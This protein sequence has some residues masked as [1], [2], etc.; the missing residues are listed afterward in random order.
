MY[1]TINN[2]RDVKQ[3]DDQGNP[4]FNVVIGNQPIGVTGMEKG[5]VTYSHVD[6]NIASKATLTILNFIVPAGKVVELENVQASG[7]GFALYEVQIN[8]NTIM[9]KRTYYT[10]YN[11]EFNLENGKLMASDDV[12]V[13]I[14]NRS[15]N[16]CDFDATLTYRIYDA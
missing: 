2:N 9:R 15:G 11:A 8:S 12:K 5:E 13:I 10:E 7:D 4:A 1:S 3:L 16:A 14:T 6:S